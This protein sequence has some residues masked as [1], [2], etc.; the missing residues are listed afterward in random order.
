MSRHPAAQ[1]AEAQ[2]AQARGDRLPLVRRARVCDAVLDHTSV[3]K[4]TEEKWNLPAP[5]APTARDAACS[6]R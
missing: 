5:T 1:I 2:G 3:L 4:L 6:R